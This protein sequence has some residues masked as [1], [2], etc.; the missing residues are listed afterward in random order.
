[1][2]TEARPETISED[3]GASS[4]RDTT[5]ADACGGS[6]LVE[7]FA[8][9]PDRPGRLLLADAVGRS[10]TSVTPIDRVED[11]RRLAALR[12]V[13]TTETEP[14]AVLTE[15]LRWCRD[16][17]AVLWE[18]LGDPACQA[19]RTE[20]LRPFHEQVSSPAAIPVIDASTRQ[21]LDAGL[22]KVPDRIPAVVAAHVFAQ[23]LDARYAHAFGRAL[24][25]RG[26]VELR[27]GDPLPLD[28]PGLRQVVSV[29]LTSPPWRLANRL[30]ETRHIRLAGRWAE[31]FRVVLDFGL[32]GAL[33]GLADASSSVATCH[34]NRSVEELR[35][36]QVHRGRLFPVAPA[37][38]AAQQKVL[39]DLIG[40]AV[41]AGARIVVLPELSVTARLAARLQRWV[42]RPDGLT[43]LVAG[44]YHHSEHGRGRNTAATWVRGVTDPLVADKYSPGDRPLPEGIEPEGRPEVRVHV[45]DG[46]HLVVAICRDLLNPN[47]V[48]ALSEVGANLVL[49]PAM[50]E[51]VLAF[52]GQ[53]AQLVGS[54]QAVV[55]VANNPAAWPH[56][57][58][59][60]SSVP[61]AVF[62]HPSLPQQTV[63]MDTPHVD[64][65]VALLELGTGA[66]RWL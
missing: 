8:G 12:A 51:R 44:S 46:W 38:E 17:H 66:T 65:G 41:D 61:R 48:H 45:A 34:P 40:Q 63:L 37:D 35:L 55:A 47:A 50:S 1:M 58:G 16:D 62:G 30:D 18:Q 7:R 21:L 27:V 36:G 24:R 2:T 23:L 20:A 42:E 11:R 56:L 59:P 49:V 15:M 33:A 22:G 6:E 60:A 19:W 13:V 3:P 10:A 5:P 28:D 9:A 43:V 32:T 31:E 64:P 52:A 26:P 4:T 53:A 54:C 14:L 29:P 25:R 39:D 57:D